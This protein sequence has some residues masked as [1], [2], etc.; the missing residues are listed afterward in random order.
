MRARIAAQLFAPENRKWWTVAAVSF[1]LFMIMLDNTVVNVA[2]PSI[3]RSL[4][5]DQS[6]LEWVVVSYA[7]T[8]ATFMLTGG[9]LA[10]YFGR[11]RLFIIGLAIFTL[12]S[13]ACGLAPNASFLIGARAVQGLG[14]AI[15]NPA[16]LGIITA[17]FPPRQ[18]GMAIGIWAGV[19]A[20]ALAIGPLLGGLITDHIDWSWIFFVNVPVGVLGIIVARWAIDESRDTSHDQRL[21]LPGLATSAV[22]LFALTYALIEANTYGW[23]SPRIL[24]IFAVAAIALTAFVLLELRQ[25]VPMLDLS[26]FRDPTFTGANLTM[27]LVSLAMFGIFFFNSL[28]LQNVLGYSA[29]QTGRGLPA[30]DRADHRRGALGRPLLGQGGVEVARRHRHDARLP[31]ARALRTARRGLDVLGHPPRPDHGRT[32]N[33][34]GDDADDSGGDGRRRRGQGRSGLGRPQLLAPGGRIPRHRRH[35]R[36]RRQPGRSDRP[37]ALAGRAVHRRLSPRPLRGLGHR[38]VRRCGGNPHRPQA[39]APRAARGGGSMTVTRS[40]LAAT[41]RRA[42]IVDAALSVFSARTYGGATTAE[43]ARA[44]GV[45]EPILYR[46][47]DSKRELFLT[48]VDEV[49]RRLREAV[50]E[51]IAA[52]PD[53]AGWVLAVPRAITSLKRR[54]LAPTQL[55]LHALSEATDD[56]EIRRHFRRHLREVHDYVA[57]VLRRAQAAG[58]I[59]PDRDVEAEAWIGIG[60]G[61]LRSVQDR[62][63]GLLGEE[64]IDA[65]ASSRVQWLTGG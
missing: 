4:D 12:A 8:F 44:A 58:A 18:R 5:A 38:A 54:R 13:L 27:L 53:P 32:G 60:V 25:R 63:G 34:P 15:M 59:D 11:R 19:S 49:W 2:L 10:D 65:I 29:T 47:F 50:E 55:W 23:T 28:F 26:L 61:L 6:E 39:R 17:T 24:V 51:E 33:G 16:T 40:R 31:V 42:A 56:E 14:A 30:D 45:T 57:G 46:H 22:G 41:D 64:E 48:C 52:E 37:A 9:K 62:F 1:G 20:M 21:D 43:I 36:D 7:L 3:Q 35:G